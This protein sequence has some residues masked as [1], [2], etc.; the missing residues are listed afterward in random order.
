MGTG[1]GMTGLGPGIEEAGLRFTVEGLTNFECAETGQGLMQ[2][3]LE[4]QEAKKKPRVKHGA[5]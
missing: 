4:K 1:V 2:V 5:F 3:F